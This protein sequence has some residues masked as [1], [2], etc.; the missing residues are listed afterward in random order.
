MLY[1]YYL[2]NTCAWFEKYDVGS[3]REKTQQQLI[4]QFILDASLGEMFG[5]PL[6]GRWRRARPRTVHAKVTKS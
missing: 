3:K 5:T 4:V 6:R 2:I 1:T